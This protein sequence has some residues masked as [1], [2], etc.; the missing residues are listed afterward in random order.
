MYIDADGG[1]TT[2]SA[3]TTST[4]VT[5]GG[6]NPTTPTGSSAQG[7]SNQPMGCSDRG[8]TTTTKVIFPFS[9]SQAF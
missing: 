3:S 7:G 8:C 6:S 1:A 4:S 2:R 9:L 5:Q